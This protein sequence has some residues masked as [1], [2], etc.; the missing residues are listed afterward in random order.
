MRELRLRPSLPQGDRGNVTDEVL[1]FVDASARAQ[2]SD[3][4]LNIALEASAGTGKTRV[5]VDRYLRLL[6]E[7]TAPRHILAITFTR[8]AAG[9]MIPNDRARSEKRSHDVTVSPKLSDLGID[10]RQSSRWQS[11]A[12]IPRP[13]GLRHRPRMHE[14]TGRLLGCED[15]VICL[16]KQLGRLLR[17]QKPAPRTRSNRN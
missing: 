4:T 7:G 15:F 5:L 2:A 8:K 16:A 12:R 13:V 10:R 6:E 17:R 11:I 9:E 14:R 1:S 3:P